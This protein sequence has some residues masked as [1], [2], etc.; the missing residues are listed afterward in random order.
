MKHNRL[1]RILTLLLTAT[2]LLSLAA[3]TVTIHASDMMEGIQP[4]KV[5][6]TK[7]LSESSAT[8]TEFAVRLFQSE[9]DPKKNT[10]VSPLSALFAL[11]M[12]ANGASGNTLKQMEQAF[13]MDVDDLN[14]YMYSYR[15]ALEQAPNGT[16]SIANSI[17]FNE[18]ERF[19]PKK[20]FLQTNAN[21]Y[22]AS[23]YQSPFDASTVRD[24]NNWCKEKTHGMI[25]KLLEEIPADAVMYLI[26]ALAFEAEWEKRYEDGSILDRTFTKEDGTQQTITAMFSHEDRYLEN[27]LAT[28]FVKY[29][30]NRNFAFVALLPKD[31]SSLENFVA[32]LSGDQISALLA[33]QTYEEVSVMLPKFELEYSTDLVGA[34]SNM[35]ITDLFSP[36]TANLSALGHST[37]GDLYV[38]RVIH[39]TFISVGELGTKAG[40]VTAVEVK[41]EGAPFIPHTVYLNRPFVYMLVDCE[42]NIPFFIGTV[43]QIES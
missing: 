30:K 11:A 17:W 3:C 5:T 20:A 27:D 35:G 2:M 21:Y 24:I 26:N 10:L 4:K 23:I 39:K 8:L 38:S 40:A 34:L 37:A 7:D 16:I 18:A 32:S 13:G 41:D 42:T 28:G 36:V 1:Q 31:A 9:N 14:K 43:T 29:Y 6:G 15:A 22:G 12:T 19:S 33:S 25:P